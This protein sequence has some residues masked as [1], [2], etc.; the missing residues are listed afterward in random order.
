MLLQAVSSMPALNDQAGDLPVH[1]KMR[2]KLADKLL[3][4]GFR[5]QADLQELFPLPGDHLEAGYMNLPKLVDRA[6]YEEYHATR[7]PAAEAAEW[8]QTAAALLERLNPKLLH[9]LESMTPEQREAEKAAQGET[10]AATIN[11]LGALQQQMQK[12]EGA[13]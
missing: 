5:H 13:A 9:R 4:F 12:N 10:V 11:Q 8:E 2:E 3:A 7:D 6:A 1:P